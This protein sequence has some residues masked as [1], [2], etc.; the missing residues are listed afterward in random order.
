MSGKIIVAVSLVLVV[1]WISPAAGET[2]SVSD[3]SEPFVLGYY[4]AWVKETYPADSVDFTILTHVIHAFAWPEADGS[5]S[6]WD[7]FLYPDIVDKCH[8]DGRKILVAFGGWGNCKGFP[9]MS[10]TPE[11]RA[12]FIGNVM[13]FCDRHGYDG[14]DIDWEF[15]AN[16]GERDNLTKLVTE[17][18]A[19]ADKLG[20]PFLITMA[21]SAGTWSSD[22]NDY[23]ALKSKVDWFNDMTYDFYGTWT[24]RSGHNAP[25]YAAQES[26][27][28]SIRFLTAQMGIPPEKIL[29]GLPFYGRRFKTSMLFGPKTGGEGINYR[30][31]VTRLDEGWTRRWDD[32]CMVPYLVSPARDSMIF[33]DDPESIAIKCAYS[34]EKNLRGVMIWSIGSDFIDGRQPL[35]ETI[36]KTFRLN[37]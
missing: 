25:L 13:E 32:V 22:H 2:S 9:P 14:I 21:V 34:R 30:D 15:P 20:K 29:L 27:D 28:T 35:L 18:R 10:A 37:K 33:Y 3:V 16:P 11:T 26:V 36:G 6:L 31:I 23:G 7:G 5:I 12:R 4:P 1:L 17:L 24:D 8:R 19:E